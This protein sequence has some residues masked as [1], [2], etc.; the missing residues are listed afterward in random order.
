MTVHAGKRIWTDEELLSMPK[1]GFKREIVGGEV[2]M[3][4]ASFD[5]GSMISRLYVALGKLVYENKLGELADGQTGFRFKSEDVFCPDIA[6]VT[7][8]RTA[9]HRKTG[10]AFFEGGPDLVV[11][12]LSP[13]DTMQV[14]EEKL[15]QFFAEG[16]RLA[17][18]VHPKRRVVHVYRSPV[19][20]RI[21]TANDFLDGEDVVPGFK[22]A[23]AKLLL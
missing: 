8:Q 18:V 3:S 15:G 13:S 2:I 17:W 12:V 7:A 19:A 4:P 14:M 20:S 1:D 11:E 9:E 21:L 5:H 10:K 23:I 16:T 6:F 22:F